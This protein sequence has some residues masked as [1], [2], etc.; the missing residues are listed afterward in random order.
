MKRFATLS[1]LVSLSV[2][3]AGP[4]DDL[5]IAAELND[6]RSIAA[7]LA[8]GVDPNLADDRGRLAI[9]IAAREDSVRA[10]EALVA[11]P[12]L[13][14]DAPNGNDE[15][16]LM[17]A[18]IRGSLAAVQAMVRRGAAVNR[19]GWTPLH[20]AASG[21]DNGVTAF[22]IAQGASL[23]ARSPNGSTA[24]MMAARYGNSTVVPVLLK[25]GADVTLANEQGMTAA[26]F[27]KRDGRDGLARELAVLI[28]EKKR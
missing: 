23:D 7:L 13:K 26:D 25:A 9:F 4:V 3:Q 22:L 19:P 1:L 16:A 10:V 20:Y 2:A 28:A 27:A 5:V 14:I 11:S 24:L 12:V 18:A 17:I 8:K 21:P 6:G 15:T